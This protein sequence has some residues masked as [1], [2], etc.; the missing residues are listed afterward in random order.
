MTTNPEA[1]L[2]KAQRS[3]CWRCG[4]HVFSLQDVTRLC[5]GYH[6]KLCG[7]CLNDWD[8]YILEHPAFIRAQELDCEYNSAFAIASATGNPCADDLKEITAKQRAQ[9]RQLFTLAETWS[10]DV[11]ERPKPEPPP[12]ATE[13]E[14]AE[15]KERR[16]KRLQAQLRMIED[17]E[18]EA[19]L[20]SS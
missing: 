20:L 5:G 9:Q 19:V 2:P 16:K 13:E 14:I 7:E 8:V 17:Q 18:K 4:A 6:A 11:I 12:P 10:D 15:M 1:H 3:G